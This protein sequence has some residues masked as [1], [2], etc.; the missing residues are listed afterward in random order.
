[1][2]MELQKITKLLFSLFL[3]I[4]VAFA[5]ESENFFIKI[6]SDSGKITAIP[7]G[8]FHITPDDNSSSDEINVTI[9]PKDEWRLISPADGKLVIS[10]K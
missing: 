2:G 4:G 1:M 5:D 6:S 7:D 8:S 9:T 3:L 10:E